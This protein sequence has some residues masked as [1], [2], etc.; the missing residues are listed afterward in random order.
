MKNPLGKPSYKD[1][2]KWS[3]PEGQTRF[4]AQKSSDWTNG[5]EWLKTAVGTEGI[6]DDWK[7]LCGKCLGTQAEG[8]GRR[9]SKTSR[10]QRATVYMS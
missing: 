4:S 7:G 6:A 1:A 9:E 3:L 10:Q 2:K 5:C 8:E